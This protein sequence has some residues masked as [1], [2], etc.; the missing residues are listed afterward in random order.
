MPMTKVTAPTSAIAV[1]KEKPEFTLSSL[2]QRII[3]AFKLYFH[4]PDKNYIKEQ[5]ISIF[6]ARP[7]A[8]I[9]WK[10]DLNT[11]KNTVVALVSEFNK[12]KPKDA[13]LETT[14]YNIRHLFLMS[15]VDICKDPEWLLDNYKYAYGR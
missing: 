8:G 7:K 5:A 10:D 4:G 11:R 9:A 1:F 6:T 13:F 12:K 3:E 2:I 14:I 15:Y